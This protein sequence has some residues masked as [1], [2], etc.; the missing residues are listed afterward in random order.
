MSV[1]PLLQTTMLLV[2]ELKVVVAVIVV[3][4]CAK[5][6]FTSKSDVGDVVLIPTPFCAWTKGMP[7]NTKAMAKDTGRKTRVDTVFMI[8]REGGLI[9]D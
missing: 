7:D 2:V 4:A 1:A 3:T 9:F 8:R 5:E 6:P